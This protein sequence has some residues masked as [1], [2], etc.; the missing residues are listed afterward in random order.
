MTVQTSAPT[1]PELSRSG[2][3]RDTERFAGGRFSGEAH[4]VRASMAS[5]RMSQR[6]TTTGVAHGEDRHPEGLALLRV[7]RPPP[8]RESKTALPF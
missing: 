2:S 6:T 3:P 5:A 7:T 1:S 8:C 4:N